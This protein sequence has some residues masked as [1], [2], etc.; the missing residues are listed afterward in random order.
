MTTKATK[1]TKASEV[2]VTKEQLKKFKKDRTTFLMTTRFNNTTLKENRT[3]LQKKEN[4]K[5]IYC[6]QYQVATDIPL[7]SHMFVLEMNNDTNR[8]AGIGL[9][10]NHHFNYKYSVYENKAY[11]RYIYIGHYHIERK[12]MTV[13]EEVLMKYLDNKCFRG[14]RHL[15][16]GRGLTQFPCPLLCYWS[17]KVDI[18]EKL[19]QMFKDR[20]DNKDNKDNKSKKINKTK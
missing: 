18:V 14:N 9:V 6:A 2:E 11:H 10:R 20:K 13:E 1:T 16:R 7:E 3:Y 4:I 15:K 8:I 5:C 17:K 12:S 19:K